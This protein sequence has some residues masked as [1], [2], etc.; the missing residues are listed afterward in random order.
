[1]F[2]GQS[3][4]HNEI[5]SIR[6]LPNFF[7]VPFAPWKRKKYSRLLSRI[8]FFDIHDTQQKNIITILYRKNSHFLFKLY[9]H[10]KGLPYFKKIK[11][12][13]TDSLAVNI[14]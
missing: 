3:L 13:N 5:A 11:E 10:E 8:F 2:Q 4:R 7:P 9:T 12:K 1:M 6:N 14:W